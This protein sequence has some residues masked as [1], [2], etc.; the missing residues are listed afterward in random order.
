MKEHCMLYMS[1]AEEKKKKRWGQVLVELYVSV[2]FQIAGK[3]GV[4][5][6]WWTWAHSIK[7][8][9]PVIAA[10]YRIK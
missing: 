6:V 5:I 9:R 1:K 2:I 3:S 8:E 7:A 10:E 4:N